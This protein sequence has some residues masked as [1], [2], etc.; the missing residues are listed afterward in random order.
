MYSPL[1]WAPICWRRLSTSFRASSGSI[2]TLACAKTW[3]CPPTRFPPE[4]PDSSQAISIC[5]AAA[6]TSSPHPPRPRLPSETADQCP[7]WVNRPGTLAVSLGRAWGHVVI[8]E[9]GGWVRL[10]DGRVQ[11]GMVRRG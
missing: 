5:R 9:D 10:G 4:K 11:T 6:I 8:F 1:P 3:F 7:R 2:R